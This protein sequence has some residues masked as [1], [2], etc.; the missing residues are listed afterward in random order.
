ME[1]PSRVGV[2]HC[3]CGPRQ[4][5]CDILPGPWGHAS[6]QGCQICSSF[7]TVVFHCPSRCVHPA[8]RKLPSLQIFYSSPTESPNDRERLR[9][10]EVTSL[11]QL[12]NGKHPCI[13]LPGL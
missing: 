10:K 7:H 13:Q 1:Q 6:R 5:G 8:N 12:S 2:A 4:K 11:C 3:G 9:L